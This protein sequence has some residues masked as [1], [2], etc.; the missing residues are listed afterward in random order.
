[1]VCYL[2]QEA[3]MHRAATRRLAL[4]TTALCA[5]GLLS[6]RAGAEVA[7]VIT[8]DPNQLIGG[9]VS[10]SQAGDSLNS[11][12]TLLDAVASGALTQQDGNVVQLDISVG[13]DLL[14]SAALR[15]SQ[16]FA[17]ARGN[18]STSLLGQLPGVPADPPGAAIAGAGILT[19]TTL[20]DATL[21]ATA[22]DNLVGLPLTVDAPAVVAI[23]LDA[24]VILA[25]GAFIGSLSSIEL[26]PSLDLR[27]PA[28]PAS[29]D[30]QGTVLV[31]LQASLSVASSQI[32]AGFGSDPNVPQ[33]Q[34][35]PPATALSSGNVIQLALSGV[36][37]GFLG[38]R[39]G[40]DAN[41]II[42]RAGSNANDG[43][44]LLRNEITTAGGTQ[45]GPG[46]YQGTA[47]LLNQQNS[48]DTSDPDSD[49][50][51]Q[52]ITALLVD[53]TI[54]GSV[55]AGTVGQAAAPL[56]SFALALDDSLLSAQATINAT[57]GEIAFAPALALQGTQAPLDQGAGDS[58]LLLQERLGLRA[59]LAD[60]VIV[61]R[62]S[63]NRREAIDPVAYA[64]VLDSAVAGTLTT[65]AAFASLALDG[66]GLQAAVTGNNNDSV[67]QN[68]LDTA[69]GEIA[70][71]VD[72]TVARLN[73]QWV[74]A[75]E[76]E[77]LVAGDGTAV[78]ASLDLLAPVGDQSAALTLDNNI[79]S[80]RT[81]GN[82][83][84]ADI[85]FAAGD[86]ALDLATLGPAGAVDNAGASLSSFRGA[87]NDG[88]TFGASAGAAAISY[89]VLNSAAASHGE[90]D[91]LVPGVRA[92]VAESAIVGSVTLEGPRDDGSNLTL[93]L[94]A[95]GN[96][97]EARAAGNRYQ[98]ISQLDAAGRFTGSVGVLGVQID[99]DQSVLASLSDSGLALTLD[100]T[101]VDAAAFAATVAV[102]DNAVLAV[103]GINTSSLGIT[104]Q[105][106]ELAA[107][108]WNSLY[109]AA[110]PTLSLGGLVEG[111][112]FNSFRVTRH[113]S[114]VNAAFALL[115]DQTVDEGDAD[116]QL[117][118]SGVIVTLQGDP[119]GLLENVS[120]Q[121][122]GNRLV[123][124]ARLNDAGNAIQID[125]ATLAAVEGESSGPLAGIVSAQG[126]GQGF[127]PAQNEP[128]LPERE[129]H[130]GALSVDNPIRVL[131]PA[132]TAST[133]VVD[134]NQL[135]AT[136][137]ANVVA[138]AVTLDA[139][140]LLAAL[141]TP[142]SLAILH[143]ANNTDFDLAVLGSVFIT[144]S[145]RNEWQLFGGGP[146]P[147]VTAYLGGDTGIQVISGGE[148]ENSELVISN[149]ALVGE[150]R[151]NVAQNVITL[152]AVTLAA[153]G[154]ILSRQGNSGDVSATLE[155]AA[156]AIELNAG[157]GSDAAAATNIVVEGNAISSMAL[158][159][160]V[161]NQITATAKGS[162]QGF[163]GTPG[164]VTEEAPVTGGAT[165]VTA[166]YAILN[167]QVNQGT[168]DRPLEINSTVSGGQILVSL[169]G[170]YP[171]TT[172][173]TRDN[174]VSALAYGNV[175]SNAISLRAP[176]GDMPSSA[177]VNQQNNSHANITATVSGSGVN[178][179]LAG[180][181]AGSGLLGG[182]NGVTAS[183]TGNAATNTMSA[184]G[185]GSPGAN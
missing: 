103:A 13:A 101:A 146:G 139:T 148:L 153:S 90:Q 183:A 172:V 179:G 50:L 87:T 15:G 97:L 133:I 120:L 178:L 2:E 169:N 131:L 104:L 134:G 39:A 156:I 94:G 66:N 11:I 53:N 170:D 24:A 119:T 167:R 31:E 83:G 93:A 20:H 51:G 85:D 42:A 84:T 154:Q 22:L 173:T 168:A 61:S 75:P 70:T 137:A 100:A 56:D 176:G 54:L 174:S 136:A 57:R 128:D 52:G 114:Y 157:P 88:D 121:V 96:L 125:T 106:G 165:T 113:N 80:A 19:G 8:I 126:S 72:V 164:M 124:Q 166:D 86:L 48:D 18:S 17:V 77:A 29:Y 44:I 67:L 102:S 135:G 45:T 122:E 62:Q 177:I 95:S 150:A 141:D 118:G 79:V 34:G 49:F 129:S 14:F 123:A 161:L 138:N 144:S 43:S 140:S 152:N 21:L 16:L 27:A 76:F 35:L 105:A 117:T 155:G 160:A 151:A 99:N 12:L 107:G 47:L 40:L 142:P 111:Y 1:M 109:D 92:V 112:R 184:Y 175:A 59:A 171:A 71:F 110:D 9:T 68:R 162:F 58:S 5:A 36:A 30:D 132:M 143:N 73:W 74:S 65:P 108:G 23:D 63:A 32:N 130:A 116:A 127:V 149:N 147:A 7:S 38:G 3:M 158:G 41:Q 37:D 82:A 180:N 60:Y 163:D 26:V 46:L 81:N 185:G 89:Q 28:G 78:G 91:F 98:S 33:D 6:T 64:L 10:T 55:T 25:D 69:D 115:N 182:N 145:Q 4:A 159:N 181:G